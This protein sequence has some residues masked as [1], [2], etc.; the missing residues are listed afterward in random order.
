[1]IYIN[2]TE[3]DR[4]NLSDAQDP[5]V[6]QILATTPVV[7]DRPTETHAQYGIA[8]NQNLPAG[9]PVEIAISLHN[10]SSGSSDLGFD[11]RVYAIEVDEEATP[12]FFK[13]AINA[14]ETDDEYSLSWDSQSGQNYRIEFNDDLT[15]SWTPVGA[16]S[17]PA[18][19]SGRNLETVVNTDRKGFYRIIQIP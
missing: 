3:A 19:A 2:G 12:D 17:I 10:A 14:G 5:S 11:M 7:D 9:E 6:W 18:N 4:I 8:L 13:L 15:G 1:M 16:A